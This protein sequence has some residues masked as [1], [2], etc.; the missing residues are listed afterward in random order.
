M[1]IKLTRRSIFKTGA[2]AVVGVAA[3][4]FVGIPALAGYATGPAVR[5]NAFNMGN[6][7]PILVGYRKA[8][9]SMRA[10]PPSDPCSWSYQAAIHGT[11][12]TP[13][14]TAWNTCHIDP[15]YF[16]SWH[17][18]Y[19]Y[20][21]ERIVRK[22]SGMYDWA[23]PFWDWANPLERQLPPAFRI[24]GSALY[25][26]SRTAGLNDGTASVSTSYGNSVTLAY[27]NLDFLL[28]QSAFNGPH[29]GIHGA[30]SGNMCCVSS[31]AQ[32]PIFW[33]HHSTVDRQWNLWLAQGGGRTDP[34]SDAD[35]RNH[36]FTFF[37][38]CCKEV[39][40]RGCDVLR[41]AKQLSYTY[42]CEPPQVEQYCPRIWRPPSFEVAVLA[43]FKKPFQLS[44]K[45]VTIPL[46]AA[47]ADN[48]A[49]APKVLQSALAPGKT[50]VLQIKG[51]EAE[52]HPG[53]S[54]EIYVGPPGMTPDPRSPYFV[55]VMGLFGGGIKTRKDH[56]HPGEF[57]FPISKA[58]FGA[59]DASKLQVI[60]V[61]ISGVEV[62]GRPVP[63]DVRSGLTVSEMNLV[64]DEAR[65]MP[66]GDEQEQLRRDDQ[67]D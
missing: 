12:A 14:L 46:S 50:V 8:I 38:E 21:F 54:W 13:V 3:Q 44:R 17:R 29:G 67:T 11:T 52:T 27:S 26:A 62:R 66:P 16:W 10:L 34:L 56:Y 39:K 36:E 19:L 2:A 4:S 15:R 65:P 57:A 23:L 59:G 6:S 48:K 9:T 47:A 51:V 20:W 32:D 35:W 33:L 28:A 53:A 55:G 60:F 30:V 40:M 22:H 1:D 64:V 58:I 25:D 18:M 63:A 7:D 45:A 24:V 41:A 37:D 5:R 42:E 31:A 43:R 61:P 49:F